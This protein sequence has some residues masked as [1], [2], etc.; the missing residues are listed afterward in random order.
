LTVLDVR[1]RPGSMPVSELEVEPCFSVVLPR[2]G[3][4]VQDVE[5][6][7]VVADPTTAVFLAKGKVHRT[8]HPTDEGDR[9]TDIAL[10]DDVAEPFTDRTGSFPVLARPIPI[11][12][13]VSHRRMVAAIDG[14]AATVL[15]IDE[16]AM[17]L[18]SALLAM[19]VA[20]AGRSIVDDARAYLAANYRADFD[21]TEMARSVG[22]S[23]HHLS[24]LFHRATGRTLS[25]HRTELRVR[26]AID[27]V[28]GG[29]TDLSRVAVESG[30]YDHAHLT[31]TI[32]RHTGTTPSA[33]R[34][35]LRPV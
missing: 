15:A 1:C 4:Y 14:G 13:Y 34:L 3:V 17:T 33:L 10:S 16:W 31:R 27:L 8:A 9:N 29:A 28:A 7:R 12:A 24:R 11:A 32:R 18:V 23:P 30:F 19:P 22:S 21:L 35:E 25:R 26:H 5:G 20:E 6:R 2:H